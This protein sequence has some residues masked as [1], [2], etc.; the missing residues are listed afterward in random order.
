MLNVYKIRRYNP[1]GLHRL[2][3]KKYLFITVAVTFFYIMGSNIG[4]GLFYPD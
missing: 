3:F 2:I 4:I 1:F